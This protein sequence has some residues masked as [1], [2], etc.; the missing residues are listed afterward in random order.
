MSEV[1][2]ISGVMI[3]GNWVLLFASYSRASIAIGTAVYNVQPFML[4]GLAALFLGEKITAQKL[5]WLAVSF[6][7]MLA[8]VSAH[9]EQGQQPAD[10]FPRGWQR[11]RQTGI[12][13]DGCGNPADDRQQGGPGGPPERH[14]ARIRFRGGAPRGPE[15]RRGSQP[16]SRT[17][18]GNWP[19]GWR[20][21]AVGQ[22][23]G[24]VEAV[25]LDLAEEGNR[26]RARR[27]L[28]DIVGRTV[29]QR[30]ERIVEVPGH[31]AFFLFERGQ[32]LLEPG[33][34]GFERLGT[35]G[36]TP[37]RQQRHR[38]AAHLHHLDHDRLE[39]IL[40]RILARAD[41]VALA[42]YLEFYGGAAD[43][44]H[45]QQ[46]PYMNDFHV[47]VLREPYGVTAHILPWNYPAQMF[48]RSVVPA[49]AMGNAA[50]LNC[51]SRSSD[52]PSLSD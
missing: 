5:F 47:V 45:G 30:G 40:K 31:H 52:L 13:R 50:V 7:G 27:E 32:G 29:G 44:V 4:V 39:A 12:C 49:L 9:G 28:G 21:P 51:G 38:A 22:P 8:I 42:R 17:H 37:Y 3:V 16:G 46:I 10:R 48:G 25:G 15:R 14:C 6:L 20:K 2:E 23:G 26:F 35:R 18:G 33:H 19:Q 11:H 24:G 41:A 1:I 34:L 43:K 36:K